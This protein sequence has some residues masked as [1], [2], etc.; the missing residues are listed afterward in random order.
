MNFLSVINGK[1]EFHRILKILISIF[2]FIGA[3]HCV[4]EDICYFLGQV[5]HSDQFNIDLDSHT[6]DAEDSNDSHSHGQSHPMFLI[7]LDHG[8][9]LIIKFLGLMLVSSLVFCLSLVFVFEKICFDINKCL[10]LIDFAQ[11]I[12]GFDQNLVVLS[13]RAPP[14]LS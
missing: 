3:N 11:P 7:S 13:L 2:I 1:R 5:E 12:Y 9:F 8:I 6:H 4:L 10:S 14:S